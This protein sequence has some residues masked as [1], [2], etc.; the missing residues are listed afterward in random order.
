MKF[1]MKIE[2]KY[3]LKPTYETYF[4]TAT[5]MATVR[6]FQIMSNK[7]NIESVAPT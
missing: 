1:D 3:N 2:N 4:M 7:L 6:H 5:N